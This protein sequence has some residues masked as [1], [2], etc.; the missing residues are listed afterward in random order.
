[1]TTLLNKLSIFGAKP[2]AVP[3]TKEALVAADC[4]FNVYD[5]VIEPDVTFE[6]R[7]SQGSFGSRRSTPSGAKGKATFKMDFEFN[8]LAIPAAIQTLFSACGMVKIG[9]VFKPF[10]RTVDSPSIPPGALKT[11][12]IG[13]FW[14]PGKFV[15]LYGASGTFKLNLPTGKP[16]FFEFEFQGVLDPEIDS[17]LVPDPVYPTPS[18]LVCRGGPVTFAGVNLCADTMSLDLGNVLYTKECSTSTQGFHFAIV[19]DREPKFTAPPE[20]DLVA[21][22]DRMGQFLNG[23]EGVLRYVLPAA[24]YNPGTGAKSVEILANQAQYMEF[25]NGDRS[26]VS[27]DEVVWMLNNAAG[28]ADSDL[29]ITFNL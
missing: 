26:G 4:A 22:Q 20:S 23:T 6:K 12:S 18:A 8:G 28:T 3:G 27:T 13:R 17:F 29:T 11:L 25:K 15:G 2:E 21:T 19:S 10:S 14:G 7:N 24:G 16:A 1:M 9:N 5:L